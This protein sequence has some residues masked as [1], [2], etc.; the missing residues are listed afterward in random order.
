MA[1]IGGNGLGIG[2]RR[3]PH[4]MQNTGTDFFAHGL[5]ADTQKRGK[6]AF[7]DRSRRLW[8]SGIATSEDVIK[9]IQIVKCAQIYFAEIL[10][11]ENL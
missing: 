3:A 2:E 9:I 7:M 11:S 4:A 8:E 5:P 10:F 6:I 1:A